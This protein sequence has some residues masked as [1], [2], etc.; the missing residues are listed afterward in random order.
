MRAPIDS[1]RFALRRAGQ[2]FEDG[3]E[4]QHGCGDTP[5]KHT[6]YRRATG[7]SEYSQRVPAPRSD[8]PGSYYGTVRPALPPVP[9]AVQSATAPSGRSGRPAARPIAPDWD[10]RGRDYSEHFPAPPLHPPRSYAAPARSAPPPSWPQSASLQN[11]P[12]AASSSLQSLPRSLRSI[13]NP[14]PVSSVPPPSAGSDTP[15]PHLWA[16]TAVAPP[17]PESLAVGLK[18]SHSES[19][20]GQADS[21]GDADRRRSRQRRDANSPTI[22]STLPAHL[23]RKLGL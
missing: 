23:S 10:T 7:A 13:L 18:R 8:L 11:P 15:Q 22:T 14:A 19:A 4:S 16:G 21:V 6:D 1:K 3:A 12:E 9:P 2:E 20:S 17:P 5:E